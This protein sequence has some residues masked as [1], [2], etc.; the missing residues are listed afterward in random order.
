MG[1][2]KNPLTFLRRLRR[3]PRF[4]SANISELRARVPSRESVT[5]ELSYYAGG[6]IMKGQRVLDIPVYDLSLI[7][8]LWEVR[9]KKY[10]QR[11]KKEKE[12]I[13][14]SALARIN[15]QWQYRIECKTM[16]ATE[17]CELQHYLEKRS[18]GISSHR[19]YP[20]VSF[21]TGEA[22]IE[23][24][25]YIFEITGE[26][27]TELPD[28]IRE[29]TYLREWHMRGTGIHRIP[30]YIEEFQELR[31]IEVPRNGIEELPVELGKLVNLRELNVS[32]NK[33]SHVPPQLGDCE[34][35]EKMELMS[36]L[37]LKE[38]PFELS[39]LKKLKYLDISSNKFHSIPICVLRMSSLQWLDI[40]NNL[41]TELPQD[42]NRLEELTSLFLHK[43]KITYLPMS[44]A[45]IPTLKMLVVS[46]DQIVCLP[47][48]LCEDPAI[49][50]IRLFDNPVEAKEGEKEK[51]EEQN[52]LDEYE[53]EFMQA[54]L[55][56]IK[57]R[58]TAPTYTTKVSLSCLL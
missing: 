51:H 12:R 42:V 43:N 41:L 4:S 16:R 5:T 57:E 47:S 39:N 46:G 19:L 13:E 56:T 8:N 36:N 32:Y 1:G 24:K 33:L 17:I 21:E 27:W 3:L 28:Y 11:Q 14:K 54:Y 29:M 40:S 34:N 7:R 2:Y 37:D 10:R 15:L 26:K 9:V 45:D 48:R 35:L 55:E 52:K 20:D 18:D 25:R 22:E 44:L 31:V 6:S 38:L 30:A 53:K 23:E 50:F 49:K 58:D